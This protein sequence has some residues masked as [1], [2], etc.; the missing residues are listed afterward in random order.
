VPAAEISRALR[1][2]AAQSLAAASTEETGGRPVER[3][4]AVR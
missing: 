2:L 1:V 4:R 3:W